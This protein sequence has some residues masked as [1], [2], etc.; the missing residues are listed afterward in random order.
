[1]TFGNWA[2]A[3]RQYIS[4]YPFTLGPTNGLTVFNLN[5]QQGMLPRPSLNAMADLFHARPDLFVNT[6]TPEN[7]V[8]PTTSLIRATSGRPSPPATRR[9]TRS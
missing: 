5:G 7:W 6:A 1:V 4:P 8:I 3:G 2:D 9:P